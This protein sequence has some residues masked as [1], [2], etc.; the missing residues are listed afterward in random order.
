MK[1]IFAC[2]LI[3]L[4]LSVLFGACNMNAPPNNTTPGVTI[5]PNVSPS[6]ADGNNTPNITG[7]AGTGDNETG[8]TGIGNNVNTGNDTNNAINRARTTDRDIVKPPANRNTNT[9]NR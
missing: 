9:N 3:V 5:T 2:V 6:P 1:R 7:N 8:G 4:L